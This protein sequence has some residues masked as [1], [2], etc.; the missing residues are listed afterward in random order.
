MVKKMR[1]GLE[2]EED[3]LCERTSCYARANL[4]RTV[5]KSYWSWPVA[6]CEGSVPTRTVVSPN[7]RGVHVPQRLYACLVKTEVPD[8]H[9]SENAIET[10]T[11]E[12]SLESGR[13]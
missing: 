9:V 2:R 1:R 3:E 8:W 5:L 7:T 10:K 6:I 4:P 12:L 11:C 13:G